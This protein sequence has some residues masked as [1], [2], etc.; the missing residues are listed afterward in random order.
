ME[1]VFKRFLY[2]SVICQ[3]MAIIILIMVL[4]IPKEQLLKASKIMN[5]EYKISIERR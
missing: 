4:L 2:F 1:E 5:L 3:T